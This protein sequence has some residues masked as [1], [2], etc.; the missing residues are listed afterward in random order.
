MKR[1]RIFV[2]VMAFLGVIAAIV[3]YAGFAEPQPTAPVT[4]IAT[5][6]TKSTP[7]DAEKPTYSIIKN[8]PTTPQQP[9]EKNTTQSSSPQTTPEPQSS[10]NSTDQ[11][12][13]NSTQEDTPVQ[14]I[15]K[16]DKD[17]TQSPKQEEINDTV[18]EEKPYFALNLPNDTYA[19]NQWSHQQTRTTTA[20]NNATGQNN[21]VLVAVI[22]SGFGLDHE[23]L[24][25]AWHTNTEEQGMTADGERCWTGTPAD[26]ARNGCDD[27]NNGYIDDWRGW[28][29]FNVDNNVQA[30]LTNPTGHGVSHG[31]EVAGLT[32]ASTNNGIGIASYHWNTKILPL[33]AL[34]DDGEGYTSDIVAAI[35]YAVNEGAKVINLS[36][37]GPSDDPN[38]IDA[39]N[40]AYS[41]GVTVVAAAG[42]CGTGR[43]NGCDPSKP[44]EMLYPAKYSHVIAVG[45]SNQ[46]EYR[47]SFSSYGPTLDVMAPGSG[48]LWSTTWSQANPTNQYATQ[49]YGTSFA[50][51]IVSSYI[52]MLYAEKPT[53]TPDDAMMIVAATARKTSTM[54]TSFYTEAYGHGIIDTNFGVTTVNSQA[55][56]APEL[57]QIGTYLS[58]HTITPTTSTS[59]GCTTDIATYCTVMLKNTNGHDRFLPY[60]S[61]NT[62]SSWQWSGSS[63]SNGNWFLYAKS[64]SLSSDTPYIFFRK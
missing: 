17:Y 16:Q 54:S 41:R 55:Q 9:E 44:G 56:T 37:G 43:E 1:K 46:N 23:D 25:D 4:P 5:P 38:L 34:S 31:T 3:L 32:G 6:Q 61:T 21:E 13:T 48:T 35:H 63:L 51:P 20:W 57:H 39:I 36:L 45:A 12:T 22:D 18:E 7:Q 42:N 2:S 53:L 59:S 14:Q 28:D 10:T 26:K 24:R 29:F 52:A 19:G 58:A 15:P 8:N 40:Y 50:S 47:A 62:Q 33:Q 60:Q 64:G 11:N 30:G 49:L 27:D